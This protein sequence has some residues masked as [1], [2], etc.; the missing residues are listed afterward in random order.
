LFNGLEMASNFLSGGLLRPVYSDS[1]V[2][3]P[4]NV[5]LKTNMFTSPILNEVREV[6]AGFCFTCHNPNGER[7]G[8]DITKREVPQLAGVQS[9][10]RPDLIRPLRDYHLVD[11]LGNQVLPQTIGGPAPAGSGPSLGATGITCDLC[12][13]VTGPDLNRSFQHDAFANT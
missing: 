8:G 9:N 4:D 11:S 13:N 6:Q 3:L 12:H 1:Q 10:F 5:P 7:V 2:V